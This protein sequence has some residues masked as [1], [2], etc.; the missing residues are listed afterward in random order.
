MVWI[1]TTRQVKL[2]YC[3]TMVFDP[4]SKIGLLNTAGVRPA[5]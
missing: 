2:A 5:E 3:G 1:T 4:P